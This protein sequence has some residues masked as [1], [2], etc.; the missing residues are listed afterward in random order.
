[1]TGKSQTFRYNI[2]HTFSCGLTLFTIWQLLCHP[3]L[4]DRIVL[5]SVCSSVRPSVR[6]V[7]AVIT[8]DAQTLRRANA[9][10]KYAAQQFWVTAA[11]GVGK[12]RT[13]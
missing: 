4:R 3:P 12:G 13:F 6:P 10:Q 9:R 2:T 8:Y 7:L 5:H 1:M 11:Y